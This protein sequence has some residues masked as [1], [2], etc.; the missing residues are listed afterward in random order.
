MTLQQGLAF[1][2]VG[3]TVR[4]VTATEITCVVNN[5]GV[6]SDHKGINV[7]DVDLSMPYISERDR[8]DIAF[9]VRQGVD[10]VAASFTR[11]AEDI[12]EVRKIFSEEGRANVSIIAKIENMQLSY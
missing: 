3:L 12:L 6:I 7:P 8:D 5:N 10:I 4:S 9:G 11:T 1:G 2:L